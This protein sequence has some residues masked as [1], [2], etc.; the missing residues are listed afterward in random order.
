MKATFALVA[1]VVA[2]LALAGNPK[3]KCGEGVICQNEPAPIDKCGEGV[4]CK[5]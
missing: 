4:I 2:N 5:K 3:P 1:L